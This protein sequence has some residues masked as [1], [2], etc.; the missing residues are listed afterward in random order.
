MP[1]EMKLNA[2]LLKETSTSHF[3]LMQDGMDK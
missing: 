1:G 2:K 3:I